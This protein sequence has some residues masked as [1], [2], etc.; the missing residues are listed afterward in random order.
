MNRLDI[1]FTSDSQ[2]CAGWFYPAD[3]EGPAPC[4]VMAHGLAAVKEMRLDAYAERF[5]AAGY[6]FEPYT[7]DDFEIFVAD[8]L[9][10]LEQSLK[11]S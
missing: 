3:V 9:T 6:H 4:I 1:S 10:F 11:A 2:T 5:S 7:G 8:Q